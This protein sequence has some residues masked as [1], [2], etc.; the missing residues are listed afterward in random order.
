AVVV[1]ASAPPVLAASPHTP[2]IPAPRPTLKP[3]SRVL[4]SPLFVCRQCGRGFARK[5]DMQRHERLH[6]G[7]RWSVGVV[8]GLL[9]GRMG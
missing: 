7:V 3:P 5:H 9:R 8:D 4:M 1:A 6:E 2:V